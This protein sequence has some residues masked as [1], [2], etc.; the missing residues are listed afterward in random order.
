MRLA[1]F[2]QEEV[3]RQ[4]RL[5]DLTNFQLDYNIY[6]CYRAMWSQLNEAIWYGR[7]GAIEEAAGRCK[8]NKG[9]KRAQWS[10]HR[11][12]PTELL[13]RSIEAPWEEPTPD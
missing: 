5:R 3:M 13:G 2:Y 12:S 6:E 4:S 9:R 11:F 8:R 1:L 10:P 7:K